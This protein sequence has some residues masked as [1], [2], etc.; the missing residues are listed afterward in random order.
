MEKDSM[1][2]TIQTQTGLRTAD[3]W[4][5][6][7]Q[8]LIAQDPMEDRDLSRMLVMN[9]KTGQ[10]EHKIFRDIID[11]L[12]PGDTLVLNDTR[13][14]PARLLGTKEGTGANAEILL[15][16]RRSGDVWETLVRPGK[17][18]RPGARVSFGDGLLT[19]EILEIIDHHRLGSL[20]TVNPVY[21]RNEPVGC[22]ATIVWQMFHEKDIEIPE[23]IAGLLC[24][25]I[26]SDTLAFRS[27]TCTMLDRL[28]AKELAATAG[29]DPEKHAKAMFTAG[30]KLREK[31]PEEI[32]YNDF[33][34]FDNDGTIMGIGQVTSM[35]QEELDEIKDRMMPF[36]EKKYKEKGLDM[37][38]FM[39][40]NIIDESTT[41]LCYG[42]DVDD[43]MHSAFGVRV[44]DNIAVM[45]GIV[46]RKK[47]VVPS[48]MDALN[49][50]Q[51]L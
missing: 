39:L 36:I 17:K 10:I 46:S 44:K 41:M 27:P 40:T 34:T 24:S 9:R 18:L 33:K 30:S 49:R 1:S 47:Q 48:M 16:K 8:E 32:F 13:V 20:E 19:A 3:Y 35:S 51:E 50:D 23:N 38:L 37:A 42:D 4:F 26:L 15:L 25:A 43:I 6:L 2:D 29:I 7:P 12:D 45:K 5:D 11:Y 21:F 28:A 22:T 31:T 14:I